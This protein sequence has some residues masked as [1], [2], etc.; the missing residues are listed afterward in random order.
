MWLLIWH[1]FICT[2]LIGDN[3]DEILKKRVTE[4]SFLHV[5]SVGQQA[6]LGVQG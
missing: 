5:R 2:Y 3:L 1:G 4:L 6:L